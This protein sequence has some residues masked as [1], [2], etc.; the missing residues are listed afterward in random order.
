LTELPLWT[1]A[2]V[3]LVVE[4]VVEIVNVFFLLISLNP[5]AT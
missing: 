2:V 3:L 5:G 1:F 4:L